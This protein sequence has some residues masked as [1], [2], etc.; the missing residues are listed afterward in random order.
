[1]SPDEPRWFGPPFDPSVARGVGHV[2]TCVPSCPSIPS[3]FQSRATGVI[4]DS[5]LG[6]SSPRENEHPLAT[7]RRANACRAEH[8]PFRIEPEGGQVAEYAVEPSNNESAHVLHEDVARSHVANDP[9]KL[10]PEPRALAVE[11]SAFAGEAD[12]LAREAA[13]DAIHDATPRSSVEGAD[14][15]VDRRRI[16]GL[17]FHPRHES[18]CGVGFPL[19]VA[20]ST[21]VGSGEPDAE[22]E[23]SNA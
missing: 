17:V 14:V 18:G 9:S 2:A 22:V 11:T 6:R 15:T 12:V 8:A 21:S 1:M 7:V 23:P 20:N 10:S 16:Q 19:D 13:S 3:P 5:R 4:H